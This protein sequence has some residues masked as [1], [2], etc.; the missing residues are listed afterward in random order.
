MFNRYDI[1]YYGQSLSVEYVVHKLFGLGD[2]PAVVVICLVV[3]HYC[4][5][6]AYICCRKH[7]MI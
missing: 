1:L 5:C 3:P 6:R 4:H 7:W 2:K